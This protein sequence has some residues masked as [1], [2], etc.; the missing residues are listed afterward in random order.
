MRQGPPGQDP[1]R[2]RPLEEAEKETAAAAALERDAMAERTR[3]AHARAAHEHAVAV[4]GDPDV[5]RDDD[6]KDGRCTLPRWRRPAPCHP[7]PRWPPPSTICTLRPSACNISGASSLPS[8]ISMPATT[9]AGAIRFSSSLGSTRWRATSLP[10]CL[11]SSFLTGHTW[12]VLPN[13]GSPGRSPPTSSRLLS[14]VRTL[15]MLPGSPS[16]PSS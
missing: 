9:T 5:H 16:R 2:T 10:T 3:A 12:T 14:T 11:R 7:S 8:L 13:P 1:C 4:E 15:P 6:V